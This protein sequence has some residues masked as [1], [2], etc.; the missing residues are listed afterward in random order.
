M[1]GIKWCYLAEGWLSKKHVKANGEPSKW[2]IAFAARKL[3]I[4][5]LLSLLFGYSAV[6]NRKNS[7]ASYK[8]STI[9][10]DAAR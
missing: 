5:I 10:P 8:T 6:G 7:C 2:V 3:A 4:L 9:C 1:E